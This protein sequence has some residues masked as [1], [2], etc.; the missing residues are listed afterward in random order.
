MGKDIRRI[1]E[2][3]R[4]GPS[5]HTCAGA[6]TK[7]L[8]KPPAKLRTVMVLPILLLLT[9]V[10]S[11]CGGGSSSSG[12]DGAENQV[13]LRLASALEASHPYIT[14]GADPLAKQLQE[15]NTG[16]QLEV[17]AGGQLGDDQQAAQQT[18]S[19]DVD[20]VITTFSTLAQFYEK[21]SVFDATYAMRDADHLEKVFEGEVGTEVR[22]EMLSESNLR[23]IATPLYGTRHVT[24]K[25]PV[26]SPEDMNGIKIR[27]IDEPLFLANSRVLGAN[28]TPVPIAELFTALQQGVV[29]AQENPIP[30]IATNDFM[31]HQSHLNLTGHVVQTLPWAMNGDSW[32]NLT[33]EQQDQLSS[34]MDQA[35]QD[36]RDCVEEDTE[37]F[38]QEWKD[39]PE[40]TVVE[41]VDKS[42]FQENAREI[43]LPKF[44]DQW[45]GLYER[46]QDVQ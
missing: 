38:L 30:T 26:R 7:E 24:S 12:G 14:C 5:D 33:S 23:L 37:K 8:E 46:I 15:D 3:G 11:A 39:D 16:I 21:L 10:A 43:L 1:E 31:A 18:Q 41:D 13:T 9:V 19:G 22:E 34:G 17:F 42:A 40:I 45:D 32:E 44:S 20:I 28:P 4:I 2:T 27:S 6:Q 35:S 29:D 25:V 36:I